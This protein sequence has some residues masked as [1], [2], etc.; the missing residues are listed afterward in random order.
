[1]FVVSVTDMRACLYIALHS[2]AMMMMI[3]QRTVLPSEADLRSMASEPILNLLGTSAMRLEDLITT[4]TCYS[5][6]WGSERLNPCFHS[7]L[8]SVQRIHIE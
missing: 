8:I 4:Y 6:I 7:F 2:V 1:M 3:A 5:H